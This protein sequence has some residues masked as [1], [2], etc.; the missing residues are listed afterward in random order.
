MHIL[1]TSNSWRSCPLN[2]GWMD[3]VLGFRPWGNWESLRVHAPSSGLFIEGNLRAHALSWTER[4]F[5]GFLFIY[6]LF[7]LFWF[8]FLLEVKNVNNKFKQTFLWWVYNQN[9]SNMFLRIQMSKQ[10]ELKQKKDRK[11]PSVVRKD[12]IVENVL[13]RILHQPVVVV[14]VQTRYSIQPSLSCKI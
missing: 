1:K 11:T 7:F 4:I 2:I 13:M 3:G 6:L 5:F 12:I 10:N 9:L 8:S 14:E